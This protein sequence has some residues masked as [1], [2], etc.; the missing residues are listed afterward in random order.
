MP[1]PRIAILESGCGHECCCP[2]RLHHAVAEIVSR[3]DAPIPAPTL[4]QMRE[5]LADALSADD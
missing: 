3:L 2:S 1:T 5:M 4:H